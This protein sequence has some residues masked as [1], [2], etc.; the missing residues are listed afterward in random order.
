[1]KTSFWLPVQLKRRQIFFN[2]CVCVFFFF[3]FDHLFPKVG[4]QTDGIKLVTEDQDMVSGIAL[5]LTDSAR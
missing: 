5:S 4:K 3:N 1:M 2:V